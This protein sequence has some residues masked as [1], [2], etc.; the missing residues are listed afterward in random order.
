MHVLANAHKGHFDYFCA[1]RRQHMLY[2]TEDMTIPQV[3]LIYLAPAVY[4]KRL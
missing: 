4:V 3:F 2:Y 1:F